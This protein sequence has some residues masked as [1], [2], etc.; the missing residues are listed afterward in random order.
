MSNSYTIEKSDINYSGGRYLSANPY[1]AAKK[2][3]NQ[4]F[5]KIKNDK[6]YNKFKSSKTLK[7]TLR[8]TT[9]GSNKKEFTY[10]AVQTKLD[11]PIKITI[12]G[13][14]IIYNYRIDITSLNMSL[15]KGGFRCPIEYQSTDKLNEITTDT[16]GFTCSK[17]PCRFS[18]SEMATITSFTNP[19]RFRAT[20]GCGNTNGGSCSLP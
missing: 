9:S 7:F 19:A 8:E 16:Y 14:E 17:E 12:K 3:A 10:K 11:K 20:G 5:R 18:D 13:K 1:N 4:L 2:A 6:N 15:K